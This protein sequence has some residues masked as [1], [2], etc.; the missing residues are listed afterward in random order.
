LQA[1]DVVID[2][3]QSSTG[4]TRSDNS[5]AKLIPVKKLS[6][7]NRNESDDYTAVRNILMEHPIN[8]AS[9]KKTIEVSA[10]NTLSASFRSNV[11]FGGFWEKWAI[12]NFSPSIFISPF[13]FINIYADHKISFFIPMTAIKDEVK[14]LCIQGAA[15]LAVDNAFRFFIKSDELIPVITN[16]ALKN[17][18]LTLVNKSINH[19]KGSEVY[20]YNSMYYSMSIRF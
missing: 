19:K 1:Q 3:D 20:E 4:M 6:V 18:V 15:L 13:S 5:S 10:F 7:F 17:I 2:K 8:L 14:N 9:P 11:R 12:I 16:F